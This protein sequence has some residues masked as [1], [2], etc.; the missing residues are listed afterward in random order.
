[1]GE[2]LAYYGPA[3]GKPGGVCLQ[4]RKAIEGELVEVSRGQMS[5]SHRKESPCFVKALGGFTRDS[6]VYVLRSSCWLL[7]EECI[8]RGPKKI[9]SQLRKL[10][11]RWLSLWAGARRQDSG[12][13]FRL[14]TQTLPPR[15]SYISKTSGWN[16]TL[17]RL[18]LDLLLWSHSWGIRFVSTLSLDPNF[19]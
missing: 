15:E 17:E 7:R 3:G 14:E 5:D 12:D 18:Y 1:M 8:M 4:W 11:T 13:R 16:G 19:F 9:M 6:W 10:V 2:S